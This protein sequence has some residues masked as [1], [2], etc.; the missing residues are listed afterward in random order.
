M[1]WKVAE[2]KQQFSE[3]VR[4]AATEPQFILNRD[5]PVAV[6]VAAADF[7]EYLEWKQSRGRASMASAIDDLV[8]ICREDEWTYEAPPRGDRPNPLVPSTPPKKRKKP[9]AR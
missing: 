1:E 6:L 9:R 2:A 5:R 4:R 7:G 8:A 3:V